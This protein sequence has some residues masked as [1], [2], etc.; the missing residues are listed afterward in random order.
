VSRN[1]K[2]LMGVLLSLVLAT[3]A[4]AM[5]F[6]FH[7]DL[8]NRFMLYTDQVGW[9]N[10][11]APVLD[12]DNRADSFG[13]IKYRLVATASTDDGA[14]KGVYA[15]EVGALKFGAPKTTAGASQGGSYSGDA[16]NVETRWFYT[17]FQI[18]GVASKARISMGLF[19]NTVNKYFWSETIM[20]VKVYGDNWYFAWLRPKD[21]A[22]TT[23]EDWRNNDLDTLNARYDL[24]IDPVKIGLFLS[25]FTQ[26]NSS[27]SVTLNP[28]TANEIRLFPD[29]NFDLLA[30]GIDGGWSAKTGFGKAFVN[31]DLI[32]ETGKVDKVLTG[33][34]INDMDIKAYF[35]H[36][37]I[38]VNFGAA[39]LTYTARYA[40]G[41]KDSTDKDFKNFFSVDVDM[42]DS[43]IFDEGLTD[44]N[45]FFEGPYVQDKG[46]FLNKLALDYQLDKKTRFNLAALYLQTAEKLLWTTAAGSHA[47]KN[48]GFELDAY[49]FHK[50]YDNLELAAAIGYLWSGDAM[51]FY[52]TATSRNG[53][54]DV[55]IFTSQLRVR[56]MF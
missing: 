10:S 43:L 53:K 34:A 1:L 16:V 21:T 50:L 18:P 5:K 55:D 3:P 52:E 15:I 19:S 24:K 14:V 23:G 37:D 22:T 45:Y 33:T 47:E 46:M 38:G 6:D 35:L 49:A 27:A 28:A 30:A 17:D 32:Y 4:L 12:D 11:S 7:G 29:S 2:I 20:G 44:D 56:Y 9:F 51:D 13:E 40:S 42:T 8:N 39:T 48:L 41:D 31:W 36:G 54:A 26:K 25:Y